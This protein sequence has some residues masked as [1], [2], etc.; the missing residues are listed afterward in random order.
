MAQTKFYF[1]TRSGR[2]DGTG[3][4][5]LVITHNGRSALISL[6]VFLLPNQWDGSQ[7]I[8]HPHRVALNHHIM[9]RKIAVEADIIALTASGKISRM[10]AGELKKE[11]TKQD[12]QAEGHTF[13][14]YFR[15]CTDKKVSP[16]TVSTYN[17]T[18]KHIASFDKNLASLTFEDI[19][20]DWIDRFDAHMAKLGLS[21]NT[22]AIHLRNI[23]SVCNDAID[24]EV[25]SHYPFRRVKIKTQ[26][27]RKRSLS[28][29]DLR[30]LVN[31]KCEPH[32]EEYRDMFLLSFLL[33]GINT[34]D[35]FALTSENIQKGRVVY[36]RSKTRKLYDIKIEP[37]AQTLL[38][39]YRGQR[40][41]LQGMDRNKNYRNYTA[42]I[43]DGLKCIGEVKRVGRGGLKVYTPL[44]PDISMYWARHTWATIAASLDIPRDTIAHALGH[45]NNT[46]TDI[47]IDFDQSKVDEANRRVIDWVLY[48]KK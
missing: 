37:E 11:L 18:L 14:D 29:D 35:L 16:N 28:V 48:G 30:T 36:N 26:P 46:V 31:Y 10:G 43:N 39:K 5:K 41:L 23:R 22:R 40:A 25:T 15:C 4:L 9:S 24:N 20:R 47:Y 1:D 34:V 7:V 3:L 32:I 45:G 19:T 44:H 12:T 13:A 6:G 17:Q 38:D 2:K 8:N 27:T 21:V 33:I 42:R